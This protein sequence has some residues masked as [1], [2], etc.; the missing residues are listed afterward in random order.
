MRMNSQIAARTEDE[1]IRLVRPVSARRQRRQGGNYQLELGLVLLPYLALL[2]GII[3]FGMAVFIRTTIQDATAAGIRYAVTYQVK[4]GYGMDDSIRLVTQ[5]AALGFL[6][7]TSSPAPN[8]TTATAGNPYINVKYYNPSS[9]LNT[10]VTGATGN[11][12]GNVV[13]VTAFYQWKWITNISGNGQWGA[14]ST[15]FYRDTTPLSIIAFSSDRLGSLPPG[16]SAPT[17]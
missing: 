3:D 7:A 4:S 15:S 14:A 5:D 11:S 12:P 13:E 2:L 1:A 8:S 9:G 16:T 10:E 17:R 6:G